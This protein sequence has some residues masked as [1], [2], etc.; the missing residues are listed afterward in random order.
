M[1]LASISTVFVV[2]IVGMSHPFVNLKRNYYRIASEFVIMAIIDL[3]LFS[4]DPLIEPDDKPYIGLTILIFF[5]V[6]LFAS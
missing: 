5:G 2:A 4:T 1:L 3:L 6:Y